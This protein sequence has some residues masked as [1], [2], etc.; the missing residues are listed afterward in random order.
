MRLFLKKQISPRYPD[1]YVL[2]V[3]HG[4]CSHRSKE[5]NISENIYLLPLPPYCPELNPVEHL[6][7]HVREKACANRYFDKL[8]EVVDKVERELS[9]LAQGTLAMTKTVSQMF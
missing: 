6:W 5:L 4:A 8:T 3:T 1:D 9:K 7:D 2:M